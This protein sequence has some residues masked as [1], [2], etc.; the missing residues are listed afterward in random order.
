MIVSTMGRI[1]VILVGLAACTPGP[2]TAERPDSWPVNDHGGGLGPY[3]AGRYAQQHG[4]TGTA[5][6]LFVLAAKAD[7]D[8]VELQQRAFTLLLAEGRID[9]AVPIAE[10]LLAIDEDSPLPLLL[11]GVLALE[12]GQAEQA[13][14]SFQSLPRKGLN[15]FVA[16]LMLAWARMARHDVDGA[17]DA[18]ATRAD[19]RGF[20]AIFDVHLG[21]IAELGGRPELAEQ[22]LRAAFDA[23]PSLRTIE[24]LG[25]LYQR[26][27]RLDEARALYQRYHDDQPDRSLL[28]SD[29][30]LA[31]G[32]GLRRMVD[33]PA[34]GLAEAMFD[35]ASL[36]R[37]GNAN[38]L[39]LAF[40]RMALRLRPDFPMAQLLLADVLTRQDRLSDANVV[41][42]AMKPT[43]QGGGFARQRLAINLDEAGDTEAA[44]AEFARLADER[45]DT[46]ETLMNWGDMLRRHKRFAEAV[47]VYDRAVARA[48]AEGQD[49]RLWTLHF[50]RGITL[51]RVHQWPAAEA[52]LIEALRL[53]PDQPDVLNYLGYT[54]VDQGVNLEQGREM[55]ERAVRLRPNDGAIV[56]SLGWA[57]FRMGDPVMAVK[58]LERAVELKP[59]D[60]T[61][62]E[63][64]GDALWRAGRQDEA[65]FQWTRALSLDPEPEQLD[66]LKAKVSSGQL[67]PLSPPNR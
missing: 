21:L 43:G 18:L 28:D 27:G 29:T 37:Q 17:L 14:D 59:A 40:V 47:P 53:Q 13:E 45:N 66:A 36:A 24:A 26:T 1:A 56:D 61:I 55:I 39:S 38:D 31:A 20:A 41:Y 3:L 62:N 4:D 60:P 34:E 64:L 16:P 48:R 57:V 46:I 67:P 42:R 50:A 10:G 15:A 5:A 44:L 8:T 63:H 35:T 52:D 7:P 25:G 11:K 65:R 22:H 49:S 33:T 58:H 30:L 32:K 23:Q 2:E 12:A 6:D 9:E 51:E 19:T 54:W